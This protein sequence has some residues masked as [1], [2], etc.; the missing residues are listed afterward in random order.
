V[1]ATH[2]DG[3][4]RAYRRDTGAEVWQ[5]MVGTRSPT[6]GGS[7]SVSGGGVW[8]G[9][10]LFVVSNA[11]DTG[12]TWAQ[13]PPGAW[14]PQG[15]TASAGSV[16][17]LDPATGALVSVGGTPFELGLPSTVL[18]PA[19]LNGNGILVC[20]GGKLYVSSSGHENGL[21]VIDTT[22]PPAVLRHLEDTGNAGEFGQPV[23]EHG[24]ILA[25]DTTALVKWGQ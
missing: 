25:A 21:F 20:P 2:K 10:H 11:T 5:A 16:R 17:Q 8:D 1:G 3:W 6:G 13:Y 4:F 22:K 12:G 7:T 18:G 15:G 23:R 9:T 24:S 14:S 19:T